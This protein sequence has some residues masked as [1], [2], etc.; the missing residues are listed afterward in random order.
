MFLFL[1]LVSGMIIQNILREVKSPGLPYSFSQN[2][3]FNS[4]LSLKSHKNGPFPPS[5]PL[6]LPFCCPH[7]GLANVIVLGHKGISMAT[8]C[9]GHCKLTGTF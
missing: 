3:N 9:E 5:G 6:G 8:S 7:K 2:I 4:S 1:A